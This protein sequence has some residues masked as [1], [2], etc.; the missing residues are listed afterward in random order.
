M[1]IALIGYGTEKTLEML[2]FEGSIY[3]RNNS[4]II[5]PNITS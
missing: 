2:G 3:T 5:P 1:K 4:L